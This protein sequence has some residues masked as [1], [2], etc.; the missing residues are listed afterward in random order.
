MPHQ[1][2]NALKTIFHHLLTSKSGF[3]PFGLFNRQTQQDQVKSNTDS[4]VKIVFEKD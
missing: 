1:H 2:K 4:T 3:Q